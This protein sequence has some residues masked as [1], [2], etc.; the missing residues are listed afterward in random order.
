M[1]TEDARP[2]SGSRRREALEAAMDSQW[3]EDPEGD[4]ADEDREAAPDP[5][6]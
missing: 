3:N 4:D 6:R 5:E 2:L 1:D